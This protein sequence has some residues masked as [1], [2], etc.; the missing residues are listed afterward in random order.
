MKT[1]IRTSWAI[2]LAAALAIISATSTHAWAQQDKSKAGASALQVA[3]GA[4]AWA[5]NC[6]RCHS[7]RDPKELTDEDWAVSV[8]HMRVRA[9]L[10]GDVARDIAA[11]LKASN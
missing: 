8:T 11:F 1:R 2:G 10:P 6:A 5:N 9:N 4:K 3:R 7:L